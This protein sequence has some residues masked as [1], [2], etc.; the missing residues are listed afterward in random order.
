MKTSSTLRIDIKALKN[1]KETS[2]LFSLV[3]F[4]IILFITIFSMSNLQIT[5]DKNNQLKQEVATLQNRKDN[6]LVNVKVLNEN[7]DFENYN[8][9]LGMLIPENEDYFSIIYTIQQISQASGLLIDS[10]VVSIG[11]SQSQ[12]TSISITYVD[13]QNSFM[14][15]LDLYQ[16]SG[17]RLI[18]IPKINWKSDSSGKTKIL[19]NFYTKKYIPANEQIF[20]ISKVDQK[21][22][23]NILSKVNINVLNTEA[24][25][26]AEIVDYETKDNPFEP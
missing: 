15:F 10:Y 2:M 22:V 1:R 5:K 21:K 7:G 8:Q 26:E 20:K 3:V 14:K 18:T 4:I 25:S 24:T 12:K 16:Y 17:G 23:Q 11:N 13:D 6:I 9:I 19:L